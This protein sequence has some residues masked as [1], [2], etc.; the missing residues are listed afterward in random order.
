MCGSYIKKICRICLFDWCIFK[1]QNTIFFNFAP[2]CE[3]SDR[4]LFFSFFFFSFFSVAFLMDARQAYP[5]FF[6]FKYILL[7]LLLFIPFWSSPCFKRVCANRKQFFFRPVCLIVFVLFEDLFTT[8]NST[9]YLRWLQTQTPALKIHYT[10]N[11][12]SGVWQEQICV[13]S[14]FSRASS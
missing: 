4:L 1:R 11:Q 10:K 6:F 8:I 13:L 9:A 5:Q 7:L 2:E 3:L 12:E 14:R